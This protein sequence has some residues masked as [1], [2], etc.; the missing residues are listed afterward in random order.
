MAKTKKQQLEEK[1]S[2]LVDAGNE[3]E[4]ETVDFS[5]PH[6]PKTVLEVDFPI[7][8]VNQVAAIEGNA[9]KPIYQMSKWWARRRSSVF[10]SMLLAASMKAPE[11]PINS[12]KSVWDVY[13]A[14]HQKKGSFNH[15]K[16]ADIFMGGGTT[17]VEGARLGMQMYGND[18]NPVAW[19]VVKNELADVKIDEVK[20]AVDHIETILKPQIMPYYAI[21]C[22]RGHK[23]KWLKFDSID[24]P[25]KPYF[26]E[27]SI[28]EPSVKELKDFKDKIITFEGWKNWYFNRGFQFQVMNDDFN[29]LLIP[30]EE[31]A[32]YRYW[33]PEI[34]FTFWAKHGTCQATD[35]GHRTP[36]LSSPV[37]ANKE[38]TV[39]AWEDHQCRV[40]G[41]VFDIEQKEA[42]IAPDAN[43]I[44]SEAEKKYSVLNKQ[45]EFCCPSCG[46][47]E[48]TMILKDRK[49]INKRIKLSVLLNE[50]WIRGSHKDSGGSVT[51]EPKDT[52]AWNFERSKTLKHLEY[53][54]ELPKEIKC[55][56]KGNVIKTDSNGGTIPKRSKFTCQESTC[57]RTQD[58]MQAIKATGKSSPV[59]AYAVQCYCPCCDSEK[60][61]YGGKFFSVPNIDSIN[62]AVIEWSERKDSDLSE[63]WPKS[64]LPYGLMT[65][66][67]NGD[68]PKNYGYTHWWTM[69][70]EKQLLILAQLLK[71]I[72]GLKNTNQHTKDILLG[73]FQQYLRY[74]NMFV[75][76][77]H[78]RDCPAAHLS[79]NNYHPKA[80][81]VESGVFSEIGTGN[82]ASSVNATMTG[83]QWRSNP[84]E[85]VSNDYLKNIKGVDGTSGKS[86]KVYPGDS[87]IGDRVDIFNQ[88]SNDL[89][90]IEDESMDLIIT[91]P[92]FGGLL[93]YSELSDFFYVWL[94][95]ALKKVYP[96]SFS[97]DYTMKSLEAVTNKAR[98][99]EDS[100]I[101]YRKI[102]TDCWREASRILKPGGI[103]A[104]TF[105]HSE[106]EPWVAV[107]ESLFN[108]GFYLEA[109]YPIRSD[110]TKGDNGQFGSKTIEYDIIHVCRKRVS[111]SNPISW[112]RLR[113]QMLKDI[114]QLQSILEN[115]LQT[116]LTESDLQVVKRGKALEYFSKHYGKV[117]VG[118]GREFTVREALIGINQLLNDENDSNVEPPPIEAEVLTRQ[119]LRIFN[120]T[121][122][123]QRNEMQNYLR[124]TGISSD[125]FEDKM[126]CKETNRIF[127]MASPLDFA[128]EWKERAR[129]SHSHDLDQVLFLIGACYENSGIN[130]TEVLSK[131][132]INIHPSVVSILDWFKRNGGNSEIK[133]AAIKAHRIYVSWIERHP[134][135][136]PKQLDLFDM[137]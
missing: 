83:L 67:A 97:S 84:W 57:G 15:L 30:N 21:D 130:L 96:S 74:Q 7:L 110:E 17:L 79:N 59:A 119:F 133:N 108:A 91:D 43:L 13:Y 1:I 107:L 99:G 32:Y 46:H 121:T 52:I 120:K 55:P 63:Y 65:H 22:P 62:K 27:P 101:F 98:H 44:T 4:V 3:V 9:G 35:C 78:G 70:N 29:P 111:E 12:A 77:H 6:R 95:L 26:D 127:E 36:I 68:L 60:Q 69:F 39:K 33:G 106:D 51:D 48:N 123:V 135:R 82:W 42:R 90:V 56:E 134:N 93:H 16:V 2:E 94:R 92:P 31:R 114:R 104:F 113:R 132:D 64:E 137:D 25:I 10:R 136:A 122:T 102:L 112:A 54:G 105:H 41:L 19:L 116:G 126:W 115:H 50:E 117:F 37:I 125:E 86:S 58:T 53:R 81:V 118:D 66:V 124:G 28:G 11:D 76:W 89:K 40:C 109:T 38:L 71:E 72:I 85:I 100:D 87:L 88:S 103:L 61:P 75:F 45:Q 8:P 131:P 23:G 129:K 49:T 18:L 24:I 14:N 34:I 20:Q 73:I 80:N 128:R 47:K 5:D